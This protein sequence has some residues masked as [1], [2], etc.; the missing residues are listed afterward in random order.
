MK[1]T[2]VRQLKSYTGIKENPTVTSVAGTMTQS[3]SWS[4]AFLTL[5]LKESLRISILYPHNILMA[6]CVRLSK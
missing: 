6:S 4:G 5:L 1:M 2:L 3:D